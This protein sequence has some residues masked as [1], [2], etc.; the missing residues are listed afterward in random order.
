[1]TQLLERAFAEAGKLSSAEQ[2]LL[3]SRLLAELANEDEFDRAI[4]ASAD[5]LTTLAKEALSEHRAGQT[6][7]TAATSWRTIIRVS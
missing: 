5:E 1:M 2:D 4:T 7:E 6:Q 3:A